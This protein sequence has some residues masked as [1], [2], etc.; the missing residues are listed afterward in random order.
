M[1][2][3]ENELWLTKVEPLEGESISHFLGR[4]RRAKGNRFSAATGLGKV[5]DLGAVLVRWEK[6]HFSP[7]P[8]QEELE[9][10]S[11]AALWQANLL[12]KSPVI[13]FPVDYES[14]TDLT[15]SKAQRGHL[16]VKFNGLGKYQF[17]IRC[18]K[19]H[20]CWFQRF[21]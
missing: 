15:W 1:K 7:F 21:F 13:P 16:Q 18:D 8:S 19:R 12:R 2:E 5:A 9:K 6:F 14:N 4:F 20:L 10:L 11:M 3:R 17:E